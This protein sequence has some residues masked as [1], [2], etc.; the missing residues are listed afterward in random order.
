[1]AK[2]RHHSAEFKRQAVERMRHCDNIRQLAEELQIQRRLLYAWKY[3]IEG[4]PK[5][6]SDEFIESKDQRSRRKLEQDN[7]R[8]KSALAD[9]TLE[10][11]FFRSALR[12]IK[13]GRQNN[14]DSGA[15]ASTPKSRPGR[16]RSK[17][18]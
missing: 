13:E 16:K 8:L 7:Q 14:T 18:N 10:V 17:A 11:E 9:K 15:I 3:K 5:P 12:R 1:M 6:R 2:W 4:R